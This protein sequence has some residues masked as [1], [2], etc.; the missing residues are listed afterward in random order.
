MSRVLLV[1][2]HPLV[3][4]GL[5][6][7]LTADGHDVHVAT[8]G[9]QGDVVDLTSELTPDVVVLDLDLGAEHR[10]G[11]DVLPELRSH[12]GA[13]VVLTG[14]EDPLVLARCLRAG[15]AGVVRKAEPFPT[16]L[17]KV[18]SAVGGAETTTVREREDLLAALRAHEEEVARQLEPFAALTRREA[19][20]L[21]ALME[22]RSAEQIAAANCVSMAT[23]RTQIQGVLQG[24]GVN[25][26][27]AA[28]AMA[29]QA[30][31]HL[32][33]SA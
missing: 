18:R 10:R 7:A 4:H 19:E 9:A 22:G 3:A 28:V 27:L 8:D 31:W 6:A 14:V 12:A 15:A 25:S 23:V 20:V 5:A 32:P 29:R 30:E 11:V 26:Q 16:V 33:D 21:A 1:D 2:D 17:D 13:V 24:L